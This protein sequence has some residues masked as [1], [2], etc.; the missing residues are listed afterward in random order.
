MPN[1]GS[2]PEHTILVRRSRDD[3]EWVG[4]ETLHDH[5]TC[6]YVAVI[7]SCTLS[8][9]IPAAMSW[10]SSKVGLEERAL[11]PLSLAPDSTTSSRAVLS[12]SQVFG[13]RAVGEE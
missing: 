12:V 7:R 2:Q 5:T 11:G 4:C 9:D 8:S 3:D 6:S 10:P 13:L 1:Q